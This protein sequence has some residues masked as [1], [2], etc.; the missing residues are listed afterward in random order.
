MYSKEIEEL[1][2][3]KSNLINVK[4]Y[5]KICNSPQV[6]HVKFDNGLFYLWTTDNYNFVLRIR[7]EEENE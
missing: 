4:E 5:I 1:L 2:R 7:K 6:D 3:L